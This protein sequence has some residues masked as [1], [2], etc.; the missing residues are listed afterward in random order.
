MC[1]EIFL[2]A[3]QTL[4][5]PDLWSR[6]KSTLKK[7]LNL[8]L[9][10]SPVW[11]LL[12]HVDSIMLWTL[13]HYKTQ[14]GYLGPISAKKKKHRCVLLAGSAASEN[15]NGLDIFKTGKATRLIH[16]NYEILSEQNCYQV[17]LK[18]LPGG[19]R[20]G[21]GWRKLLSLNQEILLC[22]RWRRYCSIRWPL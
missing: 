18:H 21:I 12:W 14:M 11:D 17:Y 22:L 13:C 15:G 10:M 6:I 9:P 19:I 16:S 4:P 8:V 1:G 20:N 3:A 7:K 2:W 5:V